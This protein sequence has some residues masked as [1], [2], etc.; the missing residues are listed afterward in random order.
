MVARQSK[1][2]G[3]VLEALGGQ[4]PDDGAVFVR[5]VLLTADQA[6]GE[7]TFVGSFIKPIAMPPALVG[8]EVTVALEILGRRRVLTPTAVV[9]DEA[10]EV[11]ILEVEWVVAD[12]ASHADSGD[13][14]A[15]TAYR[16]QVNRA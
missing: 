15:L 12:D 9:W 7:R 13:V 4:R 11:C 1:G 3:A 2:V 5:L 6:T 8:P 10:H 16:R 14:P